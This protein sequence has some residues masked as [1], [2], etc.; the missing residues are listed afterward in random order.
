M[1]KLSVWSNVWNTVI[2]YSAEDALKVWC[3]FFGEDF[4]ECRETKGN[5]SF[6][7]SKVDDSVDIIFMDPAG[8][9][10]TTKKAPEWAALYGR[11]LLCTSEIPQ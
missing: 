3:D 10:L 7:F 11:G 2:A 8:K 1:K 4:K 6:M 5:A 9:K